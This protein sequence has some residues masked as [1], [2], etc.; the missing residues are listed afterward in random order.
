MI[1]D[2]DCR[3]CSLWVRRWQQATGDEVDYLPSQDPRVAAQVPELP[4][5]QFD[6]AVQLVEPEGTVFGGA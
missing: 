3:F 6:A 4:R 5:E 2:G 1:Y